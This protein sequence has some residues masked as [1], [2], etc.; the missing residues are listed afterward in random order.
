MD[1]ENGQLFRNLRVQ[2]KLGEGTMGVVYL[3]SHPILD[4]CFVVKVGKGTPTKDPFAE[5][6]LASRMTSPFVV[7][8]IDAGFESNIPFII[9]SIY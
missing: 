4:S 8:V 3:A 2:S 6:R 9:C 7:D 1:I 5:A